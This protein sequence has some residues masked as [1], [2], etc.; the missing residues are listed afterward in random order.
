MFPAQL[1]Q[2]APF[3]LRSGLP[4]F[5]RPA[6]ERGVV[7]L[8]H[9]LREDWPCA[10]PLP[11]GFGSLPCKNE[12]N[13]SQSASQAT[14]KIN[15]WFAKHVAILG[16][17]AAVLYGAREHFVFCSV[18]PPSSHKAACLP[19]GHPD[20]ETVS[21][22][23]IL[24]NHPGTPENGVRGQRQHIETHLP[25]AFFCVCANGKRRKGH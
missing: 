16:W 13:D 7:S 17:T 9:W 18:W 19:P 23:W 15:G 6:M 22:N 21:R 1:V 14:I 25:S 10:S 4:A 12:G 3:P 11:C 24:E 20:L 5:C 2:L 8:E